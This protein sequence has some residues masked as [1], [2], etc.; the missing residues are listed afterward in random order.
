[1][2]NPFSLAEADYPDHYEPRD[3]QQTTMGGFERHYQEIEE[4]MAIL[5]YSSTISHN[6]D[7]PGLYALNFGLSSYLSR[8]LQ[9]VVHDHPELLK[10][11]SGAICDGGSLLFHRSLWE[12]INNDFTQETGKPHPRIEWLAQA[13]LYI[14]SCVLGCEDEFVLP[15]NYDGPANIQATV[16][17]KD[18]SVQ[19]TIT[20]VHPDDLYHALQKAYQNQ[21]S[22]RAVQ[23]FLGYERSGK[24]PN[25][26][27]RWINAIE[28]Y[29]HDLSIAFPK[30]H[31]IPSL[32]E[33]KAEALKRNPQFKSFQA[34]TTSDILNCQFFFPMDGQYSAHDISYRFYETTNEQE[35]LAFV[36]ATQQQGLCD[37][38][39]IKALFSN[40][41]FRSGSNTISE[42]QKI[43][44]AQ[45]IAG[46]Q[47]S[48]RSNIESIVDALSGTLKLIKPYND[49]KERG[50]LAASLKEKG[51]KI[52]GKIKDENLL[53]IAGNVLF[54]DEE[55]RVHNTPYLGEKRLEEYYQYAHSQLLKDLK[56][57]RFPFLGE[58]DTVNN[59]SL[60][61]MEKSS[62]LLA[63]C[64]NRYSIEV[65]NDLLDKDPTISAAIVDSQGNG[66]G[67]LLLNQVNKR[68]EE[69]L[70]YLLM[71]LFK[72]G[73]KRDGKNID[74]H[75]AGERHDD[76]PDLL[77]HTIIERTYALYQKQ[78]LQ[79]DQCEQPT[80]RLSLSRRI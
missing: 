50:L 58:K 17:P 77:T 43:K 70:E 48:T 4:E 78:T 16:F 52:N 73:L 32:L 34:Y 9:V 37:S 19:Q 31:P 56:L 6:K 49:F 23:E 51:V 61:D 79:E 66:I 69:K 67:H 54:Y 33:I 80:K 11:G 10:L 30:Q 42:K 55:H 35:I 75:L 27:A 74:G 13:F 63:A 59:P 64:R 25:H 22:I 76:R 40:G 14:G 44:I 18:I 29:Q 2:N 68:H 26:Q 12:K 15:E 21:A 38:S 1:M 46:S 8:A 39:L 53:Q 41:S 24:A 45:T 47:H 65:I 3:Q 72:H 20:M 62:L 7:V 36:N 60:T 71:R 57:I 28:N 5:Q